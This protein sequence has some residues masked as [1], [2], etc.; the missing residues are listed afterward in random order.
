MLEMQ[1]R[2]YPVLQKRRT[3]QSWQQP[4]SIDP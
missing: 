2:L 4:W 3:M 1:K